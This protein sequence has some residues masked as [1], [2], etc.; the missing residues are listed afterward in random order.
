MTRFI[1]STR[2]ILDTFDVAVLDQWGVLHN[3]S[4]PYPHAAEAI[5]LLQERGKHIVILSNSGKRSAINLERIAD[6]GLP[7]EHISD[8]VTSGEAL[9]DDLLSTA[10]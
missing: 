4:V 2:E 8:V 10:W 1:Q 9:R 6:M 3:G 5:A 7:T